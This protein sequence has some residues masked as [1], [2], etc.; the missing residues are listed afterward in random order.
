LYDDDPRQGVIEGRTF[1][2]PDLRFSFDA[3]AGY[4]ISNSSSAVSVSG[5]EGQAIFSTLPYNGNLEQFA[6]QAVQRHVGQAQT[7]LSQPERTS[8]NGLPA[9]AVQ[10]RARTQSGTA[11]LT[12]IAYEFSNNQAYYVASLTQGGRGA[13]A[14]G[15]MF[16][17]V[18]RLSP[19]DVAGIRP[20]VIDVVTV[21]ARDTVDTLARRMAY[22]TYQ[23]ERFRVLNGL[24]A[25]ESVQPGQRVK[26]VCTARRRAEVKRAQREGRR[27]IVRRPPLV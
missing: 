25:G 26:L 23:T 17:S 6:L 13:G 27:T 18:R 8:I 22:T 5:R 11:D 14:F 21:G 24:T 10:A 2:H 3:P 1:R 20:R 16:Q 7:Q 9:V 19:Q 15:P 12:V 4:G